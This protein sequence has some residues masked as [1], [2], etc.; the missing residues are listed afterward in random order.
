[1][2]FRSLP[3][4]VLIV[5]LFSFNFSPASAAMWSSLSLLALA[6]LLAP[7]D[8]KPAFKTIVSAV[9]ETGLAVVDIVL[10]TAA[11]GIVIGVLG[12]SGL[13]FNLT[14]ALVSI[15]GGIFAMKGPAGRRG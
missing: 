5:L 15:G 13:G 9:R 14:L 7:K 10:I 1:M 3:F 11:A 6:W 12:I 2:L 4:V 8:V